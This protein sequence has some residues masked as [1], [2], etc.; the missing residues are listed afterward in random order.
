[1]EV[2]LTV[3]LL[4]LILFYWGPALMRLGVRYLLRYFAKK[5]AEQQQARTGTQQQQRAQQT[6]GQRRQQG[7]SRTH[8]SEQTGKIFQKD[9]GEYIDFE[10]IKS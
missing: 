2:L 6:S 5:A 8:A 3:I 4:V 9:E 1:M 7:G 10:E